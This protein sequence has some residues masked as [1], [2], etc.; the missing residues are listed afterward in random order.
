MKSI[1]FTGAVY[2]YIFLLFNSGFSLYSQETAP[3]S[4]NASAAAAE[5]SIDR[6]TDS[7][8]DPDL[9]AFEKNL[10]SSMTELFRTFA[11]AE[12]RG[13]LEI[14]DK[15]EIRIENEPLFRSFYKYLFLTRSYSGSPYELELYAEVSAAVLGS[16]IKQPEI[17]KEYNAENITA[18]LVFLSSYGYAEAFPAVYRIK[19]AGFPAWL[20]KSAEDAA[21]DY[22]GSAFENMKSV[23]L[24]NPLSD[25]YEVLESAW[26]DKRI[27][28]VEKGALY[29]TAMKLTFSFKAADHRESSMLSG[30]QRLCIRRFSELK[31]SEA[32]PLVIKYLDQMTGY[33]NIRL[34]KEQIIDAVNCLGSLM[35][36]EAALRLS[37]YLG[38]INSF[39]ENKLDYEQDIVIAVIK[40]LGRLGDFTAFENLSSVKKIS[41]PEEVIRQAE[42]S[43]SALKIRK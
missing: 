33:K 12:L 17:L 38:V 19:S 18:S 40:N 1:R 21:A 30:I 42:L 31:W 27:S 22:K 9:S 11:A 6:N 4:G 10:D 29:E 2:F 35:T 28:A 34:V 3:A 15:T 20:R 25:K 24:K 26:T 32:T 8:T 14:V 7:K 39:A 16:I 41:Y 5:F 37:M 23:V 36:N 43:L 13:K